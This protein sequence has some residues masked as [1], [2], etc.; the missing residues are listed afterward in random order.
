MWNLIILDEFNAWVLSLP[1]HIQTAIAARLALLRQQGPQLGRPYADTLKGSKVP[2]LKEL[3]V[4][5][6]GEPYRVLF[7]FDPRRN[8]VILLG[9]NKAGDKRWYETAIPIA[10][11]RFQRHLDTLN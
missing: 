4:P 5:V 9:G 11:A 7:A 10:E 3:R 2:N 6:A 1:A 8:A